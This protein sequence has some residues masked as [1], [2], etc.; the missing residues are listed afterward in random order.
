M[1]TTSTLYCLLAISLRQ[2]IVANKY[3]LSFIDI[4]LVRPRISNVKSQA[5][6]TKR[7]QLCIVILLFVVVLFAILKLT[8]IYLL[9]R[10]PQCFVL[11]S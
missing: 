5:Q 2:L 4:R 8:F 7:L 6:R 1:C 9:K 10:R 3:R 11:N